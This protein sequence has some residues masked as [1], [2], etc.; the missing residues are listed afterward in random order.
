MPTYEYKC[1]ECEGKFDVIH[2]MNSKHEKCEICGS[3]NIKKIFS[4]VFFTVVGGTQKFGTCG[5]TGRNRD[6]VKKMKENESRR[7]KNE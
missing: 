3:L 7:S 6:L 5:Y 2:S 1:N 4:P